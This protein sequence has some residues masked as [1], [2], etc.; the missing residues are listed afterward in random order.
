[1]LVF[2]E[3]QVKMGRAILLTKVLPHGAVELENSEGRRFMV[4]SQRIKIYLGNVE[5]VQ[6]VSRLSILI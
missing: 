6:Q 5:S 3:T 2:G 1:M 4:N